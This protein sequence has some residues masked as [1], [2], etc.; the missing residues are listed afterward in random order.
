M[1]SRISP[2]DRT[3]RHE[4]PTA[5]A[6][7]LEELKRRDP[8]AGLHLDRD[9]GYL[10][11]RVDKPGSGHDA[12]PGVICVQAL[13][14]YL[15]VAD[16][17]GGRGSHPLAGSCHA[18]LASRLVL[19]RL[20][21]LVRDILAYGA[22]QKGADAIGHDLFEMLRKARDHAAHAG[23][24]Q[25]NPFPGRMQSDL[26]TTFI[27][28]ELARLPGQFDLPVVVNTYN[29]GDSRAYVL[30]TAACGGLA[31]L[32][33]DDTGNGDD[34]MACLLAD[35]PLQRFLTADRFQPITFRSHVVRAPC[36]VFVASDGFH[37]HVRTP[38]S[39]ER[40]LR[41]A[42]RRALAD[43]DPL[44]CLGRLL[45]GYFSKH[46]HDDVS[47]AFQFVGGDPVA[48]MTALTRPDAER[49]RYAALCDEEKQA[50]DP[51]RARASWDAR[52]TAFARHLETQR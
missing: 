2:T 33:V 14:R 18:A 31:A 38:F 43:P 48:V 27:M 11:L 37:H 23:E 35:E 12:T 25:V 13:S 41:A 17:M 16:G 50:G 45:E 15:A 26:P 4:P 36:I 44:H 30:E 39:V 8:G 49:D 52:R 24:M 29:C 3:A 5:G 40:L 32:S 21:M 34:A 28:A 51:V 20:A 10:T 42:M 47:A 22:G 19:D 7:A 1:E 46:L 6:S 9:K